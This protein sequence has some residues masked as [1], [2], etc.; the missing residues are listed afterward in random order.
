MTEGFAMPTE[1]DTHIRVNAVQQSTIPPYAYT[2]GLRPKTGHELVCAGALRYTVQEVATILRASAAE[3][4]RADP[5]VPDVVAVAGVGDF[6]LGDVHHQWLVGLI[7]AEFRDEP[8][9]R[10]KQVIPLRP[11]PTIDIPDL[12]APRSFVR[13]PAWRWLDH[14]WD[15]GAPSGSHL[16]T[17]LSVLSGRTPVTIFRWE[18]DQWEALDV[19]AGDVNRADA[20]VAPLGL[21]TMIVDD[22]SQFLRLGVGEGLQLVAGQWTSA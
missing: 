14:R 6:V 9:G 15:V 5:Q 12:S 10:W 17:T 13:D 11:G 7:P 2:V 4:V 22:W 18:V 1:K 3:M 8:G 16:V 19:P 21:L 20:R